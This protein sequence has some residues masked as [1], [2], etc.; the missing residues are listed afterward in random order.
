MLRPTAVEVKVMENYLLQIKF[1]NGEEKLFD[2]ASLIIR[3]PYLPLK[4]IS[5]F[6]TAHANGITVEWSGEID[7]C[8]DELYYGSTEL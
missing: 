5:V 8:P 7:I 6:K 4:D 2:A 1:D 3:K